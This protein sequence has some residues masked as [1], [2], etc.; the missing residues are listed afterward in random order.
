MAT[1]A[2]LTQSSVA[3]VSNGNITLPLPDG[4]QA[5]DLLVASVCFKNTQ[6]FSVPAGSPWNFSVQYGAA[7]TYSG[8]ST[9]NYPQSS[10]FMAWMI[11]GETPPST[12]FTR[13]SG[14]VAL[15][16]IEAYRDLD[17]GVIEMMGATRDS[18]RPF[19][20]TARNYATINGITTTDP[21]NLIVFNLWGADDAAGF[22][23]FATTIPN[24]ESS[25]LT[26]FSGE[27]PSVN[28]AYHT[29]FSKTTTGLDVS[30]ATG[31]MV[32]SATGST[33]TIYGYTDYTAIHSL[34]V[35]QFRS[36]VTVTS[37]I[38]GG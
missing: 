24:N 34:A 19:S 5:G 25:G 18:Y 15:G 7:T 10:G 12:T 20:G 37:V 2:R 9:P 14:N 1:W 4:V 30:L 28:Q 3:V 8:W 6:L 32:K 35:T 22:I 29:L 31:S 23:K 36:L 26:N 27:F 21:N 13:S 38:I 17:G 16:T 33:S 11:M